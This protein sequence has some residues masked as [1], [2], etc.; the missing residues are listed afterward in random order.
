MPCGF[1]LFGL[2]HQMLLCGRSRWY[3][4]LGP[5]SNAHGIIRWLLLISKPSCP[6]AIMFDPII[7]VLLLGGTNYHGYQFQSS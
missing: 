2:W 6:T 3:V 5:D 1:L 4:C 7:N